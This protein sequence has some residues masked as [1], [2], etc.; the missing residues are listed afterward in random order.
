MERLTFQN[1]KK[2]QKSIKIGGY[3]VIGVV[4]LFIFW[5][6]GSIFG[7]GLDHDEIEKI[8]G[9]TWTFTNADYIMG[10]YMEGYIELTITKTE[11][12]YDYVL[13]DK[14]WDG[15]SYAY[16]KDAYYTGTM[17][18]E[19]TT[20]SGYK[21]WDPNYETTYWEFEDGGA[22]GNYGINV[23]DDGSL[24]SPVA[25]VDVELRYLGSNGEPNKVIS[26]N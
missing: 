18:D 26:S 17:K 6:I 5:I 11:E 20:W 23:N 13:S 19:Y 7:G 2:N 15:C 25:G 24:M 9:K 12:G 22:A 14:V 8:E 4:V 1:L 21:S 16:T 3:I 10:C